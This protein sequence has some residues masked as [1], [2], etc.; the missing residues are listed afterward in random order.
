M[1]AYSMS[2]PTRSSLRD[3]MS[4]GSFENSAAPAPVV[5]DVAAAF[6]FESFRQAGARSNPTRTMLPAPVGTDLKRPPWC[7]GGTLPED[8]GQC[9]G[10]LLEG[11]VAHLAGADPDHLLHRAD[12]HLAV[13]DR[14]GA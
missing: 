3:W 6:G 8:G 10:T 4:A 14:L 11:V 13:A 1:G 2:E 7:T 9:R 12:P 5:V